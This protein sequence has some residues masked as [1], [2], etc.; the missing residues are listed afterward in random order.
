MPHTYAFRSAGWL[1][2]WLSAE[3]RRPLIQTSI[4]VCSWAH[5]GLLAQMGSTLQLM[6]AA[7][8]QSHSSSICMHMCACAHGCG[9]LDTTAEMFTGFLIRCFENFG[10][11]CRH[12][13]CSMCVSTALVFFFKSLRCSVSVRLGI[14]CQASGWHL[15]H[16]STTWCKQSASTWQ[17]KPDLIIFVRPDQHRLIFVI[18]YDW[19]CLIFPH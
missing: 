1:N 17:C 19:S 9:G 5:Q 2:L 14:F 12:V 10:T 15:K 6:K 18:R 13:W 7:S 3:W 11:R 8:R 4:H 16:C